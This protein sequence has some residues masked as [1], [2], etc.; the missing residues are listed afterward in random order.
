M[1]RTIGDIYA[2]DPRFGGNPK[3]TISDPDIAMYDFD[4]KDELIIMGSK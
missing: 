4:S 1:S 2:K 3:A